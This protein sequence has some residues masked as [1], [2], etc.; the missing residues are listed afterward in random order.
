MG[1]ESII[2]GTVDRGE[3]VTQVSR[4]REIRYLEC[5]IVSVARDQ[6]H[7]RER[8]IGPGSEEEECVEWTHHCEDECGYDSDEYSLDPGQREAGLHALGVPRSRVWVE[9][10]ASEE[11]APEAFY[12]SKTNSAYAQNWE[13]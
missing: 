13:D 8:V 2:I 4:E 7:A 11:N 1:D 12:C 10:F 9:L 5:V 3:P 6:S